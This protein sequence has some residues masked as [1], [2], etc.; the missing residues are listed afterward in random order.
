MKET[1][2]KETSL[3]SVTSCHNGDAKPPSGRGEREEIIGLSLERVRCGS[4]EIRRDSRKGKV[5][6][7]FECAAQIKSA[8]ITLNGRHPP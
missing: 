2:L 3:I 4:R 1:G 7:V 6:I 5:I 8:D